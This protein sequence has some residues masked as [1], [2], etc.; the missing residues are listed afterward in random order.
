M[1]KIEWT[2]KTVNPFVGCRKI[3]AGC[4]HCYAEK[5]SMRLC[6]MGQEKYFPV[7][8]PNGWN[9]NTNFAKKE[10]KK[11][12][13]W[14]KPRMIF[15]V[16]MGDL[17]HENNATNDIAMV[18]AAMYL[19]QRHTFQLLTKR[20]RDAEFVLK[21]ENFWSSYHKYCNSLHDEYI[22]PLEQ[23]L[24]FFDEVREEWP[25]K[26]VWLGV[27]A[28]NQEQA[29]KRIPILLQIP[30]AKRFV[31][32][33]PM[34]GPIGLLNTERGGGDYRSIMDDID[35]VIVGSESGPNRR[36]FEESWARIVRNACVLHK[37]PFFYK[38]RYIGTKKF[39]MPSLDGKVWDQTP[40]R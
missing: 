9:G 5:M 18:F 29:N 11:L 10:L 24:Y 39:S 3:S 1:T 6:A 17:F 27:T 33:E 19:N 40:E 7:V 37:V 28:E 4:N 23:E 21:D 15:M 2:S 35:W 36:S 34:L 8:T 22:K 32:C 31:S 20:P 25:L 26:N 14:K 16:S 30:A 38:Q 12:F 13:D